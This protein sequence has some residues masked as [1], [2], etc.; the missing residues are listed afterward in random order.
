MV[1]LFKQVRSNTIPIK[2]LTGS[3]QEIDTVIIKFTWKCSVL[4]ILTIVKEKNN[5]GGVIILNLQN[6]KAYYKA[7]IIKTTLLLT[8]GYTYSQCNRTESSEINRDIYNQL[9]FN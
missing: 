5:I 9:I 8:F 3:F 4:R 1:I 7:V 6:F 2:I